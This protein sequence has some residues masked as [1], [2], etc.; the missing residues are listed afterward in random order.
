MP[1][2]RFFTSAKMIYEQITEYQKF[3]HFLRRYKQ[4]II[5]SCANSAV[6]KGCHR[7]LILYNNVKGKE[8]AEKWLRKAAE[9]GIG[10]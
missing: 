2:T 3:V 5:V 7:A 1:S 8:E 10:E 6:G 9:Q 4:S